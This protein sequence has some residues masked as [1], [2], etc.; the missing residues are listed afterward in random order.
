MGSRHEAQGP[1]GC[2]LDLLQLSPEAT[3]LYQVPTGASADD[4]SLDDF[5]VILA[6]R[7]YVI[8]HDWRDI[9]LC[10]PNRDPLSV[11][12]HYE[13]P[14][15]FEVAP[16]GLWC[17]SGG[18]G[19]VIYHL[20]NPYR[21][22]CGGVECDQWWEIGRDEDDPWFVDRLRIIDGNR[23]RIDVDPDSSHGGVYDVIV[24][25][26]AVRRRHLTAVPRMEN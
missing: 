6:T 3:R 5:P 22:F 17:A 20:R 8:V 19:V 24:A 18:C 2:S 26:K 25:R 12:T 1:C 4:A 10:S 23:L 16:N 9:L 13:E 21:P 15:A 11:G 14:R 7:D